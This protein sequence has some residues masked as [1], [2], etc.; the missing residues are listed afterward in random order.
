MLDADDAD[1]MKD[2]DGKD[3][4][5]D[6]KK[7]RLKKA[8]AKKKAADGDDD[9]DEDD[10]KDP[11]AKAARARERGRIAAIMSS[12]AAMA[13]PAAALRM[14][15]QT[16]MSRDTAI[17]TLKDIGPSGR[18]NT[19]RD[20]LMQVNIPDVGQDGG[21]EMTGAAATAAAIIR[22]GKVRRGEA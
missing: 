16:S 1:E 17:A 8:R 6:A 22:A 19:G 11:K 13:N 14:A 5:D 4:T 15:V 18:A 9:T 20:R 3:E 7:A 21:S 2:G 12:N 10:D